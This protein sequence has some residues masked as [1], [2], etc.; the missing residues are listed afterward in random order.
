MEG[1]RIWKE[2]FFSA[3]FEE[4]NARSGVYPLL[5]TQNPSLA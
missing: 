1:Y 4:E 2:M 5:N 3:P